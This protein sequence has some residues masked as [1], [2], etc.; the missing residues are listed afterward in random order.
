MELSINKG[1]L[2]LIDANEFYSLNKYNFIR[3]VKASENTLKHKII[4]GAY[5][6]QSG[7]ERK[8][9]LINMLDAKGCILAY[10][11]KNECRNSYL[12][13]IEP[14]LSIDEGKIPFIGLIMTSEAIGSHRKNA[15]SFFRRH[16]ELD[17][18]SNMINRTGIFA[19][20]EQERTKEIITEINWRKFININ[21]A[22]K[23][24]AVI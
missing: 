12:C 24:A 19:V 18:T 11:D 7:V 10:I 3:E 1:K 5:I 6:L 2:I 23:C 9:G 4:Y 16:S 22:I 8:R 17:I 14:V 20:K 21:K 15:L 13:D